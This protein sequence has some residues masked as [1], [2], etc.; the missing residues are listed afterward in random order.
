[1]P[2]IERRG[3]VVGQNILLHRASAH[4][5]QVEFGQ[6]VGEVEATKRAAVAVEIECAIGSV[7]H[8]KL[9]NAV[10]FQHLGI[11][12]VKKRATEI[13]VALVRGHITAIGVDADDA[14]AS[15]H[16]PHLFRVAHHLHAFASP[17]QVHRLQ[18]LA[19]RSR[20][21]VVEKRCGRWTNSHVFHNSFSDLK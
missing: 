19:H 9:L 6:S 16:I 7:H 8:Q 18:S 15:W 5:R 12:V 2:I 1:M 11:A 14:M 20:F 13:K 4:S 10:R 17:T 21:L 3:E